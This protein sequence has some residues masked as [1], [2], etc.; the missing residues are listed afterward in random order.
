M[1]HAIWFISYKLKAGKS[2][3]EFLLASKKC[4]DEVLS[5]QKGY[6][7]WEVLRD[8]DMWVDLVKW[9]SAEDAKNGET[10][11]A[12]NPAARDFYSFINMK[13]CKLQLYIVEKSH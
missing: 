8:G 10:A 6:I 13:T 2:E 11:G 3:E 5:K 7:S 9:E 12:G 4:N 1:S